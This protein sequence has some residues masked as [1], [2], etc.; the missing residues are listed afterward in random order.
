MLVKIILFIERGRPYK[1]C[2]ICR[3]GRR[4]RE[5]TSQQDKRPR[6][7]YQMVMF[8]IWLYWLLS[9]QYT[10]SHIT[11][12]I[13]RA[14]IWGGNKLRIQHRLQCLQKQVRIVKTKYPI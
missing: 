7:T 1:I 8:G 13:Y 14:E 4:P 3:D 2:S 6:G 10:M 9:N 11:I 5:D 12:E